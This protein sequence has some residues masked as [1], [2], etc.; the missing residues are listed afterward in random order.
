M[1]FKDKLIE[2]IEI[3]NVRDLCFKTECPSGACCDC[4]WNDDNTKAALLEELSK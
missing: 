4:P 3:T 1:S 2:I